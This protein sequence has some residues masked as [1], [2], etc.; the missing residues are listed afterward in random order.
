VPWEIVGA[1]Y[2]DL[3]STAIVPY[4][5]SK[6]I[7]I[8]SE[9]RSTAQGAGTNGICG[10]SAPFFICQSFRMCELSPDMIRM[11]HL[12]GFWMRPSSPDMTSFFPGDESTIPYRTPIIHPSI[13]I[14]TDHPSIIRTKHRVSVYQSASRHKWSN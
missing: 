13:R 11:F 9:W 10:T 5:P 4:F 1:P 6:L 2:Q 8:V 14:N 7:Q 3:N 12:S